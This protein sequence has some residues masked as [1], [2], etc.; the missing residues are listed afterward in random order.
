MSV[1]IDVKISDAASPAINGLLADLG[2]V[3]LHKE[4][5]EAGVVMTARHLRANGKNKR[6]WPT[7]NFWGRSSENTS[8]SASGS[9][10]TIT[11][12]QVG[13]RQRYY[14]GTI[15]AVTKQF[16]TIPIS[17]Q[18]YGKVASDIPGAFLIRTRKGLYIVKYGSTV[19]GS[20][21]VK[22]ANTAKSFK[23]RGRHKKFT[24]R[25][26]RNASLEFLFKLVKSVNQK[27][28]PGV[29]PSDDAYFAMVEKQVARIVARRKG[30]NN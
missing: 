19:T 14:G 6:G 23:E 27:A 25:N 5:G 11:I 30:S 9:T 10:V 29:I 26:R 3:E 22:S 12:N 7:T 15:T 17:P 24:D 1:A 28:D 18:A 16:L 13:V 4:I 8:W 20:G 2:G 21:E